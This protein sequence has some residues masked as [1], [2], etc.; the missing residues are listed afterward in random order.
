MIAA[1]MPVEQSSPQTAVFLDALGTLVHLE[2]PWPA[3]AELLSERHGVL[4]SLADARSAL[5][6]EM[7][8]YRR[9]CVRAADQ[10]SLER[11]RLECAAIV[12][13]RLAPAL[14]ALSDAE[15]VTA[16]LDALRFEAYDDVVPALERWRAAGARLIVVS[17]WDISLHDVLR[18]TGLRP[19]LDGVVCSAEVGASK[20]ARAPF[21][22][23][24]ELAG[25]RS[26]RVVHIGDG[27]EE[28]VAGAQAAGI[29]A[30]L[31]HRGA[32]APE[33]PA[34]VRVIASLREW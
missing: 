7:D 13:A 2:E 12:R 23:A 6:A 26:D 15:I 32:G 21:D 28:D 10:E 5:L 17:N 11:L 14:A 22:A 4:V 30:V 31:L 20:P 34:G 8:Y 18:S 9:N 24:L 29:E 3:L 16:L 33:A 27:L 1:E 19:L 25:V